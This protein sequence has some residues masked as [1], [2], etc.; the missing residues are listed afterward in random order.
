[1]LLKICAK[2]GNKLP[3]NERCPCQSE[4][5]KLYNA[6]R[7]DKEKDTFYRS[8]QWRAIVEQVKARA[9][10]LDEYKLSQGYLEKGNTVHHIYTV[11]ERPDLKLS[12]WNLIYIST[13]TH[14]FFHSEYK[15]SDE[16]KDDLQKKL[17][18]ITGGS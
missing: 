14:N 8:R 15:R 13:K 10:G 5:H 6:E 18:K 12:V 2:C 3:H 11:E 9:N 17:I 16:S 1:M 7:R 4:R